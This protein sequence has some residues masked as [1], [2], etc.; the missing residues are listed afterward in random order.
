MDFAIG[1]MYFWACL[2]MVFAALGRRHSGGVAFGF[3]ALA[4][5]ATPIL[6]YALLMALPV[7]V[8]ETTALPAPV[9][10]PA[11]VAQ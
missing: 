7:K 1:Y 3:L 5:V 10:E 9:A 6:A 4:V 8:R 2:L 11:P